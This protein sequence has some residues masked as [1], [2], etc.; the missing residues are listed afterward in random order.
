MIMSQLTLLQSFVEDL[1]DLR[2]LQEGVFQLSHQVF[3]P[4]QIIRLV[5]ETF[6][7]QA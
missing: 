3:D 6:K 2:Q 7:P 4:N 5:L 1:L